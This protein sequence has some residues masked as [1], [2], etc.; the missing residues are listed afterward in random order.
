[1]TAEIVD[2]DD[3]AK[4]EDWHQHVLDIGQETFAVDRP[5]TQGASIRSWRSAARK[6][7][8]AMRSLGDEPLAASGAAMGARHVGL[9][10]VSS[11]K[12]KPEG[13]SRP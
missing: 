12:T 2:D 11:M 3:A 10:Q 1:M 7:S 6:V 8:A 9:A 4:L 5:I 13:S